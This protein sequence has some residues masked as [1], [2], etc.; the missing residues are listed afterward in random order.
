MAAITIAL[1]L[2]Q[3]AFADDDDR[4]PWRPDN[5]AALAIT[6][7]IIVE[8]KSL[9]VGKVRFS[10]RLDSSA[11]A[12]KPGQDK[13]PA[14]I[15]AVTRMSNPLLL[16]GQ[17]LCGDQPPTWIVVVPQ[18]P[19]GLELDVFTGVERPTSPASPGLCNRFAYV[20]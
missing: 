15:F 2:S 10:L 17:T 16:N 6:G 8:R 9:E 1:T 14:H 19:L 7:P 18:P 5:A 11:A 13:F 3:A 12:F 4:A 20:R